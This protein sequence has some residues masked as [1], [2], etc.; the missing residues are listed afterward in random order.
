MYRGS[1]ALS[2]AY[3]Q[4]RSARTKLMSE[5]QQDM[6]EANNGAPSPSGF[7]DDTGRLAHL[8]ARDPSIRLAFL[9]LGGWDT[10]VN[11]GASK[12]QLANHLQPLGEG[13]ASFATALGPQLHRSAK[14]VAV[15]CLIRILHQLRASSVWWARVLEIKRL[16]LLEEKNRRLTQFSLR[17]S[18]HLSLLQPPRTIQHILSWRISKMEMGGPTALGLASISN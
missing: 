4:G 18:S 16:K 5:L 9:A 8:I 11:Q 10:H 12:G 3:Q 6:T 14:P 1:D 7:P 2:H 13:L 15:G 17:Q